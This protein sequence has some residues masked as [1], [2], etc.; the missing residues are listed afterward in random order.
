MD[1]SSIPPP[2]PPPS[3]NPYE[4][5][6][7]QCYTVRPTPHSGGPTGAVLICGI[8]S[9]LCVPLACCCGIFGIPFTLAGCV[10]GFISIVLGMRHQRA[11]RAGARSREGSSSITAGIVLG[12]IGLG[13]CLMELLGGIGML[14]FG[15]WNSISAF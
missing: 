12:A 11:V 1:S 6:T 2:P 4:S 3:D 14:V 7:T 15:Y 9:L 13:L 8:F 10:L 5:P